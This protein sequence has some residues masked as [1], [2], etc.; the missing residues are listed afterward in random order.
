MP[1]LMPVLLGAVYGCTAPLLETELRE[2]LVVTPELGLMPSAELLLGGVS[3]LP[4]LVTVADVGAGC[5]VCCPCWYL[6]KP[7]SGGGG[8][9]NCGR[10]DAF[11]LRAVKLSRAAI[12]CGP[13]T[14]DVV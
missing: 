12:E 14:M 5:V 10:F 7:A 6:V 1:V 8:S 4:K 9:S 13:G 3:R 2:L 11:G